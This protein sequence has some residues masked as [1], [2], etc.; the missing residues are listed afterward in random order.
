MSRM[1]FASAMLVLLA[2]SS[3]AFGTTGMTRQPFS[4]LD[5]QAAFN[6]YR[7]KLKTAF[8]DWYFEFEM[9]RDANKQHSREAGAYKEGYHACKSKSD[10]GSTKGFSASNLP[11]I[12]TSVPAAVTATEYAKA[13]GNGH[14]GH[15][16]P[17][18]SS[19]EQRLQR[20][21]TF[22]SKSPRCLENIGKKMGAQDTPLPFISRYHTDAGISSRGHRKLLVSQRFE[23]FGIGSHW[24]PSTKIHAQVMNSVNGYTKKSSVSSDFL[25]NYAISLAME[26]NNGL[27]SHIQNADYNV[28]KDGSVKILPD[29]NTDLRYRS[30]LSDATV[31]LKDASG[32][33][34]CPKS[35]SDPIQFYDS[36]QTS[37]NTRAQPTIKTCGTSMSCRFVGRRR[38]NNVCG[39]D[40]VCCMYGKLFV[41]L[42]RVKPIQ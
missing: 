8:C 13:I 27:S 26:G 29:G 15:T 17:D 7:T 40:V 4:A 22:G 2:T 12:P 33:V 1:I 42:N 37:F 21:G 30:H 41:A 23:K 28:M 24:N 19:P 3:L 16:G 10:S 39:F 31:M 6:F 11:A 36:S 9:Q 38:P 35:F 5:H 20:F 25:K 32:S 14:W 34:K 18:G